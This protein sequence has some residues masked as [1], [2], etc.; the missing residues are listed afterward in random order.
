MKKT[1]VTMMKLVVIIAL[2]VIMASIFA[3]CKD[4]P[5]DEPPPEIPTVFQNKKY[6]HYNGSSFETF[7]DKVI[8]KDA[9]GATRQYVL[10]YYETSAGLNYGQ[11]TT[12]F[13][14]TSGSETAIIIY[15]YSTLEII[16]A[17]FSFLPTGSAYGWKKEG[18]PFE[19]G[20]PE[21]KGKLT[22]NGLSSFNDKYVY[23]QGLAS[24]VELIGLTSV[25]GYPSDTTYNLVKISGGKA[26]VPLYTSSSSNS[27]TSYNGNDTI[28]SLNIIIVSASSLKESN[29]SSV[30]TSNLGKKML[31]SGTFS[32]G[33]MTVNWEN[34]DKIPE[35]KGKLTINGLSSFNDKY[36]YV[37]GLA[38]GN[39]LTGLTDVTGYPSDITYKLVKISDG[40]AEVPLYAANASSSSGSFIAYD[41]YD[42]I[43]SL[44][45]IIV[46]ESSLK[47]SNAS[48]VITSN[49]GKKMLTSGTF[50]NGNMTVDWGIIDGP[51]N[52]GGAIPTQLTLNQW[53]NGSI[54]IGGEQWF[55][56]TATASTQYIHIFFGTLSNFNFK[57]FDINGNT[58]S[59][60]TSNGSESS[61]GEISYFNVSVTS[62]N[63]YYIRIRSFG[64]RSGTYKIAFNTS[65]NSP[66]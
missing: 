19:P 55:T 25:T 28:T 13:F 54:S 45:I 58:N 24:G 56:F 32:N 41:G 36:V 27:F 47:E 51:W 6:V 33:N 31:T 64:E 15:D 52:P 17:Q 60:E 23:V 34:I 5:E 2:A 62:G 46:S 30:I 22:I 66:S 37:Q 11:R 39:V 21:A 49:L 12:L 53:T 44:N 40:K 18:T 1:A 3:A 26:E 20:V 61:Y 63:K 35:A 38:G 7:K 57:I 48:S 14:K 59:Y 29:A 16:S 43:T 42:I 9:G 8:V 10:E 4:E 65:Y 50:S